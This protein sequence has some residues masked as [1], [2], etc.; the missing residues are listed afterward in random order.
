M[1]VHARTGISQD[2]IALPEVGKHSCEDA[3]DGNYTIR[4]LQLLNANSTVNVYNNRTLTLV[5]VG[6]SEISSGSELFLGTHNSFSVVDNGF[7]RGT[8]SVG[9]LLNRGFIR[10][11]GEIS[12]GFTNRGSSRIWA[13]RGGR[14]L[15]IVGGLRR[16]YDNSMFMA[17]QK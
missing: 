10:G 14:T 7:L 4:G 13:D 9:G 3:T 5:G 15:R 12:L 17:K 11:V 6:A 8:D 2:H 1:Q 16:Q